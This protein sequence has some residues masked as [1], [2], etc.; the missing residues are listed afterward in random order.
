MPYNNSPAR[1]VLS[2]PTYETLKWTTQLV[3]PALGTMYFGLGQIWGL[4]YGE[5]VVGT[6]VVVTTFLGIVLGF[7]TRNYNKSPDRF[8]GEID[9]A[10]DQT[11][12]KIFSLDL[13]DSPEALETKKE[14][15]FRVKHPEAK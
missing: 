5:E 15:A 7:S 12:K 10:Q 13:N 11:G 14:V 8:A 4:P 3:L 2:Q 6:L 9:I 1:T